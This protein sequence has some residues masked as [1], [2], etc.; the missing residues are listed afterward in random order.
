LSPAESYP[1]LA[2][3][4]QDRNLVLSRVEIGRSTAVLRGLDADRD[5]TLVPE[6]VIPAA[7]GAVQEYGGRPLVR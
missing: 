3:F 6:E 1:L 5:G 2:I 7:L 4:D